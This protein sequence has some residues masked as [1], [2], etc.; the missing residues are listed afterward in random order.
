ML[1]MLIND[2]S[3]RTRVFT[4]KT[5]THLHYD[6]R[7]L[8]QETWSGYRIALLIKLDA[9]LCTETTVPIPQ[10]KLGVLI[11]PCHGDRRSFLCISCV[12]HVNPFQDSPQVAFMRTCI[13]DDTAA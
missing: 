11:A 4:M 13:A 12:Q 3:Q 5:Y 1:L 8:N 9:S 6:F 2:G 10:V 7:R